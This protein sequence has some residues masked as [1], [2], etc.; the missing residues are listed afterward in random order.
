VT[1]SESHQSIVK[2]W[3]SDKV[4]PLWFQST[5]EFDDEIRERFESVWQQAATGKLD[6]WA[7]TPEGALALVIILDQLPLNM[8][9]GDPMS[10]STEVKSRDIASVAI[11]Q[12][13]DTELSGEQKAFLYMPFMHSESM[14]DQ[15]KSV[16]LYEAAGLENNL[17][18]A[19]HHRDII[20]RFGRFPHRNNILG[21][22]STQAEIAYLQSEEAF[23][24]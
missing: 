24:G 21:R 5:V 14:Q 1:V 6:S 3:F 22:A 8:Y 16:A 20:R 15:D 12:N 19:H 13:F 23:H 7:E 18:F 11:E 9:R 4:R 17:K 2:F 10:F